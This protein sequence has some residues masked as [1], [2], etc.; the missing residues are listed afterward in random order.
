M[1]NDDQDGIRAGIRLVLEDFLNRFFEVLIAGQRRGSI[2]DEWPRFEAWVHPKLPQPEN[3]IWCL[4][5]PKR[6]NLGHRQDQFEA[7]HPATG[8]AQVVE[9]VERPR[10]RGKESR[11]GFIWMLCDRFDLLAATDRFVSPRPH[12]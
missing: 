5:Q 9:L 12:D 4:D 6:I 10:R 2:R 3:A 8:T 7:G 11:R 1:T